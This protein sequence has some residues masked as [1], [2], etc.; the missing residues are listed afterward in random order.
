MPEGIL[1]HIVAEILSRQV[2][3]DTGKHPADASQSDQCDHL[4]AGFQ[5]D[6][7]IAHTAVSDPQDTFIHDSGHQG[8]LQQIHPRFSNHEQ[9]S[10][11][12][13]KPVFFQVFPHR[14]SS[15]SEDFNLFY[16][17]ILYLGGKS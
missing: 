14:F 13:I 11:K 16:H 10:Q 9:R 5:N 8:R 15:V 4:D 2:R 7:H 12:G 6:V 1:S 3:K 17:I